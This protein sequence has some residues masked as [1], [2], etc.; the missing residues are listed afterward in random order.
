MRA[1]QAHKQGCLH[2][3]W[4]V[5]EPRSLSAAMMAPVAVRPAMRD[6]QIAGNS[7]SRDGTSDAAYHRADRACHGTACQS[8]D[9][10]AANPFTCCGTCGQAQCRKACEKQC[11][12]RFHH[13]KL[14]R[15]IYLRV[16]QTCQNSN[17]SRLGAATQGHR[18]IATILPR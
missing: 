14:L 13:V 7:W 17:G 16:M 11:P 18:Q 3:K 4:R 5:F 10:C 9:A 8:A 2:V 15:T 6:A 1:T 12:A